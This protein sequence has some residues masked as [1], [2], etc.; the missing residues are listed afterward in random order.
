MHEP[1]PK[2]APGPF[3][4]E[5]EMCLAC[6]APFQ[7]APDLMATDHGQGDYHCRF[8]K[9]P[10][11]PAEVERAVMACCVSCTEAVRYAGNNPAMLQRF[12]ELRHEGSCDVLTTS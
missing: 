4:V 6:T 5:N 2:N 11:T 10:E 9:Q 3:Y 12:R 8:R 1:H 7:E